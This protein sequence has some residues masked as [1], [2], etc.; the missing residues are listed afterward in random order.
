[1]D[2]VSA[3]EYSAGTHHRLVLRE[4]VG[5]RVFFFDGDVDILCGIKDFTAF[6]ALNE[7]DIVLA[8]DDF[9]DGMF[10]DGS[11]WLGSANGMDFA[12]PRDSCQHRSEVFCGAEWW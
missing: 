8:G 10:A 6:L 3:N 9:D 4:V 7:F 2:C 5:E 11:H 12:R 1:M